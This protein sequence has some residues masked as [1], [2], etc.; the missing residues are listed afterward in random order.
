MQHPTCRCNA[1]YLT[2]NTSRISLSSLRCRSTSIVL[3]LQIMGRTSSILV[4]GALA[5]F[6]GVASGDSYSYSF[7]F[8]H[9]DDDGNT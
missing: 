6:L 7:S 8:E 1:H 4:G 9:S 3:A 2:L 5:L